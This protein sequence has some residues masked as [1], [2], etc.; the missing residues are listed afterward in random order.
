M[1]TGSYFRC[2]QGEVHMMQ[3]TA[4]TIHDVKSYFLWDTVPGKGCL[5]GEAV[6]QCGR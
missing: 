3:L 2:V 4:P 1:G 5:S 6:V